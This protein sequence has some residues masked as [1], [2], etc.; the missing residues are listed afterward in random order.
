MSLILGTFFE[1]KENR[2][3][4]MDIISQAAHDI[5][6]PL[7]ALNF[8]VHALKTKGLGADGIDLLNQAISRINNI[9][10]DILT[11]KKQTVSNSRG[12]DLHSLYSDLQSDF[13]ERNKVDG[14]Q[15]AIHGD[16]RQGQIVGDEAQLKRVLN[17]LMQNSKEASASKIAI[18]IEEKCDSILIKVI[19]NGNGIS[20][21]ALDKIGQDGFT[22]KDYGHGLGLYSAIQRLQSWGGSLEVSQLEMGTQVSLKLNKVH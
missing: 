18:E 7:S 10:E 16:H 22:T 17:N 8:S 12:V 13:S 5:R 1:V 2:Q 11:K 15:Y 3:S 20:Q 19:D 14:V 4:A 6:S 9:A 21:Q